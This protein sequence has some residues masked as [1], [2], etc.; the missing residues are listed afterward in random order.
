MS[1][2]LDHPASI[3]P[4]EELNLATLEPYLRRHF[5]DEPGELQVRQFP[6]GHSNLTYSLRLGS[7]EVILRRPPFGSKV[8]SAHDMGREYCVLSKLHTAYPVA[9]KAVLYCDHLSIFNS[10]FCLM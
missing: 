8:R 6:S 2:L 3:R 9:P 5:P 10:P 1:D 7:R 4:G